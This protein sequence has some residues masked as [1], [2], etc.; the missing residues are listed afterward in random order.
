MAG[1]GDPVHSHVGAD[2]GVAHHGEGTGRPPIGRRRFIVGSAA[3]ATAAALLPAVTSHAAG[4]ETRYQ[5]LTPLRLCDTRPGKSF[6]FTRSGNVTRVQIAGRT[7]SGVTVPSNATAAVFTLVGINRTDDRNFLAAFPTG[8]T[9]NGTSSLNMGYRNAIIPNLVTVRVGNGSVDILDDGNAD[10]ILDLAG[11]YI[12]SDDGRE[13]AGRFREIAPGRRVLDTRTTA[14]KPGR[15]AIVRVDLTALV[16]A[17]LLDAD[18]EAVS[19]NITAAQPSDSGYL[20]TYPFGESLPETSSL[21][22]VRGQNRAIGAMIKL[23]R[24]RDDRIGFNIFVKN[25]AHVLVDV[26]GFITGASAQLSS[27]GLFVP[28]DPVRL[29]DTRRGVP[30][31]RKRLWPGWTR[32]IELPAGMRPDAGTA[33]IN[34]TAVRTMG[35]GFFSVNAA[36]TRTGT[37]TVSSLNVAGAGQNV[38]NHVVSRVSNAGLEC[39]SQTGGD[40]LADLVGYYRGGRQQATAPVPPAPQPPAIAPPYTMAIPALGRM[41]GGRSVLTGR[42][43]P[44]VDQGNIWHWTGTGFV[45][46]GRY[47]VATFGHRTEAGGPLYFIDRL[48]TG[49]QVFMRTTDQR[50]YVYK[51][52]RREITTDQDAQILAATRRLDGQESLAV[53]AC[54]VGNDRSKSRYPDQYA[55]TSL[56]YRIVVI[57]TFEY[58]TDDIPLIT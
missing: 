1:L 56:K 42:S 37:P 48:G 55:P 29:M 13:S 10:V 26:T 46:S 45:G 19:V 18:A 17:G 3:A 57:L 34:L 9:W 15:D 31:G 25:G 49:D 35:P 8:A 58:W 7:V 52:N 41:A 47:N 14:G 6:G 54:T 43:V 22:V 2:H 12:P 39:F 36:Q 27:T 33:V 5:A 24:D 23:G 40:L 4:A 53:V 28:V 21:N 51:Y 11:V 30:G 16:G 32:A 20:T 50:T 38:A 44:I